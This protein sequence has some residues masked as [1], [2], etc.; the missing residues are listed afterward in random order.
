M[1]VSVYEK[2]ILANVYLY[3]E[4]ASLSSLS[5]VTRP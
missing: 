2:T 4:L 3:E 1:D 5:S